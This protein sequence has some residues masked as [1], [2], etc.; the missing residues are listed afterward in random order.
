MIW[1]EIICY[2]L[3][4]NY[5][6]FWSG[7]VDIVRNDTGEIV[8]TIR[9]KL[10]EEKDKAQILL[11]QKLHSA[12]AEIAV[13]VDWGNPDAVRLMFHEFDLFSRKQ[14]KFH[15]V[16]YEGIPSNEISKS[17]VNYEWCVIK[18]ILA[19]QEKYMS[20]TKKDRIRLIGGSNEE[21]NDYNLL[22]KRL[23]AR[24]FF[25]KVIINPSN[26]VIKAYHDM[27]EI[28]KKMQ[29]MGADSS[30]VGWGN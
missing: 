14:E 7:S 4:N 15:Q 24:N 21:K 12:L 9:I 28:I 18:Y 23:N 13:P 16:M 5:Q 19:F 3:R 6:N 17:I 20:L 2:P 1:Y 26:E 8:R 10:T 27:R 11:D 25:I 22:M 29:E 30:S